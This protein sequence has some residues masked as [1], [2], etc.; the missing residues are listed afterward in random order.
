MK[1][2]R[3]LQ[4]RKEKEEEERKERER[5]H[6][7][8]QIRKMYQ[9]PE[10]PHLIVHPPKTTGVEGESDKESGGAKLKSVS[11]SSLL[12]KVYAESKEDAFTVSIVK[13][14]CKIC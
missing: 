1:F 2:R 6:K 5:K 3:C 8:E 12:D 11:Y 7:Q 10:K 13:K 4:E 9:L 14:Q